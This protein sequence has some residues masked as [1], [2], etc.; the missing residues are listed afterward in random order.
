MKFSVIIPVYNVVTYVGATLDSVLHASEHAFARGDNHAVEIICVDD[1]ST[2]G[3][4][5]VLDEYREKVEKLGVVGQRMVVLHQK[6]AGVSAARNA[7]LEIAKG[8]WICFVDSDDLIGLNYFLDVIRAIER[9]PSSEMIGFGLE[10]FDTQP[11]FASCGDGPVRMVDVRKFVNEDLVNRGF[12]QFSYKRE[13]VAGMKFPPYA[14]GEDLVWRCVALSRA[15]E[16][17]IVDSCLYGYRQRAG[18]AMTKGSTPQDTRNVLKVR[19]QMFMAFQGACKNIPVSFVRGYGNAWIERTP[20]VIFKHRK[21]SAWNGVWDEW[22]DSLSA[23]DKVSVFTPWMRTVVKLI[24]GTRS[25]SL[26]FMLCIVPH[27][28]KVHGVHR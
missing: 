19:E 9:F 7:A 13:L 10:K 25:R 16:V 28:C 4:G 3:S 11:R 6:N 12:Y 24:S 5:E 14:Y 20:Y 21:D 26:A 17:V 1:G 8:D 15:T 27:W 2:D 18:S 23:A 22:L